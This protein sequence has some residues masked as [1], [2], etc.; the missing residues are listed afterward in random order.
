MVGGGHTHLATGQAL[1]RAR[2]LQKPMHM[3]YIGCGRVAFSSGFYFEE[4]EMSTG[5]VDVFILRCPLV[6]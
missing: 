2:S 1:R 6:V 5:T 4:V 3:L